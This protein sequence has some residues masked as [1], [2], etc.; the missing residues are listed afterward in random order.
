MRVFVIR[1]LLAGLLGGGALFA[2]NLADGVEERATAYERLATLRY[3]SG[4][5]LGAAADASRSLPWPLADLRASA[6]EP[7]VRRQEQAEVTYWRSEYGTLTDPIALAAAA[8]Q[9]AAGDP[10][11]MMVS[12]NA[13]FRQTQGNLADKIRSVERLD[14]VISTYAEV[15]R[16]APAT[17]DAAFNYEYVSRFR[18]SLASGRPMSRN[19]RARARAE[20]ERPPIP[21]ADLPM[22]P[23]LHGRPGGPPPEIPGSDFKTIAPMPYD[24]REQTDPGRGATPRRRG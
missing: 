13:A 6:L 23:T 16:S 12:A 20:A 5:T 18:D 9:D 19:A 15:L 1:L 2:W 21:S 11:L 22:G 10:G 8:G 24:E 17:P 14:G 4:D 3:G 7:G